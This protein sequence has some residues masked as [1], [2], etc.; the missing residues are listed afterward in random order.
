[1]VLI[2]FD[3]RSTPG[4]RLL[5][6]CLSGAWIQPFAF[7]L[8]RLKFQSTLHSKHTS[9]GITRAFPAWIA[10]HGRMICVSGVKKMKGRGALQVPLLLHYGLFVKGCM[11]T[12]LISWLAF[13]FGKWNGN[14]CNLCPWSEIT[15]HHFLLETCRPIKWSCSNTLSV[16]GA[17]MSQK[18]WTFGARFSKL[19]KATVVSAFEVLVGFCKN[20]EKVRNQPTAAVLSW[21]PYVPASRSLSVSI[22]P[23][24]FMTTSGKIR[25]RQKRQLC[26]T[27]RAQKVDESSLSMCQSKWWKQKLRPEMWGCMGWGK[28]GSLALFLPCCLVSPCHLRSTWKLKSFLTDLRDLWRQSETSSSRDKNR[29]PNSTALCHSLNLSDSEQVWLCSRPPVTQ[30]TQCKMRLSHHHNHHKHHQNHEQHVEKQ[31]KCNKPDPPYTQP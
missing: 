17:E 14:S 12:M 10:V 23:A 18:W 30:Q 19:R 9:F 31:S 27:H 28:M 26:S 15:S 29:I 7:H 22:F 1:M 2:C 24:T 25:S 13:L 4:P 11:Q 20:Q 3:Q 5:E 6:P 8:W 21:T 16:A